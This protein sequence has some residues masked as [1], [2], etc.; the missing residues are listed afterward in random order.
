[1]LGSV[2]SLTAAMNELSWRRPRPAVL[3]EANSPPDRVLWR[4]HLQ[5]PLTCPIKAAMLPFPNECGNRC[6]SVR[7]I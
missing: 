6:R 4:T 3:G 2:P 1:V 5:L 7:G